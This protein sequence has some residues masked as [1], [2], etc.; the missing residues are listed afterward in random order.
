MSVALGYVDPQKRSSEISVK[1][2]TGG[3]REY[4]TRFALPIA[5]EPLCAMTL[6]RLRNGIRL[7]L[8]IS[9]FIFVCPL[10]LNS[11]KLAKIG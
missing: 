4:P 10:A 7:S 11:L 6:G 1:E 2:R 5:L 9:S 8:Q 3:S